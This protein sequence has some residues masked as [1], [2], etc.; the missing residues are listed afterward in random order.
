VHSVTASLGKEMPT[1]S[2]PRHCSTLNEIETSANQ[3]W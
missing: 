3:I 2:M 1:A